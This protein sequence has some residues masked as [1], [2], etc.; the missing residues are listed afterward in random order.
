M[1]A[2]KYTPVTKPG[3]KLSKPIA[4]I[5]MNIPFKTVMIN[6]VAVTGSVSGVIQN[7]GL[8]IRFTTINIM[9]EVM[10]SKIGTVSKMIASFLCDFE[11]VLFICL[12]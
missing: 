12:L 11:S 2:S 7:V 9:N 8:K 10:A 1:P 6:G 3:K 5:V 4:L